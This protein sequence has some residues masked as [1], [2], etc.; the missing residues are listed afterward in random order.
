MPTKVVMET[1]IQSGAI[2]VVPLAFMPSLMMKLK[3]TNKVMGS[4]MKKLAKKYSVHM[5]M[6][7]YYSLY[8]SAIQ[9]SL[10]RFWKY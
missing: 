8:H 10:S 2:T 3:N 1:L 5:Y 4:Y 6:H 7:K 9:L